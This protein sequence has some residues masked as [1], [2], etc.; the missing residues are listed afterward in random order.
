VLINPQ[1]DTVYLPG[2]AR[3]PLGYIA[4]F[5]RSDVDLSLVRSLAVDVGWSRPWRTGFDENIRVEEIVRRL[6]H[7][8]ELHLVSEYSMFNPDIR[9]DYS[10]WGRVPEVGEPG[11]NWVDVV[12]R[13]VWEDVSHAKIRQ[14]NMARKLKAEKARYEG[15]GDGKWVLPEVVLSLVKYERIPRKPD[16]SDEEILGMLELVKTE[17]Y[18]PRR[19][20]WPDF[21]KHLTERLRILKGGLL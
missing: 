12:D 4:W 19:S 13:E 17:E 5:S 8:N 10:A 2:R 16:D 21:A 1:I 6:G 15:E 3:F 20:F 11:W 18:R 9:Y 7:V 14:E